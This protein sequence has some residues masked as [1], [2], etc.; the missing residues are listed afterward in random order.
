MGLDVIWPSPISQIEAHDKD[1]AKTRRLY[2]ETGRSPNHG[3]TAARS[4]DGTRATQAHSTDPRA[5]QSLLRAG[6]TNDFFLEM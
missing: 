1:S 2:C 5:G 3:W 4:R 6:P